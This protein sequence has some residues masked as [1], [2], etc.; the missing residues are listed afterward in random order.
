MNASS[1]CTKSYDMEN[2]VHVAA[3]TKRKYFIHSVRMEKRKNEAEKQ[4]IF[5]TMIFLA[6]KLP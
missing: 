4:M 6:Y 1:N 3:A 2:T 5:K